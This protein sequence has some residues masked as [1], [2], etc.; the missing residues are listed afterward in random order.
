MSGKKPITERSLDAFYNHVNTS[1]LKG[2]KEVLDYLM[3]TIS[4]VHV[5]EAVGHFSINVEK[6]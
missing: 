5:K 1:T 6:E 3:A 4:H 2:Q